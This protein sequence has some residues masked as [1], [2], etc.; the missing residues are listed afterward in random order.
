MSNRSSDG[1]FIARALPR[2]QF[3]RS[4]VRP[5]HAYLHITAVGSLNESLFLPCIWEAKSAPPAGVRRYDRLW[6]Q[7]QSLRENVEGLMD[8]VASLLDADSQ[9][10]YNVHDGALVQFDPL[11][12]LFM[13][14]LPPGMCMRME[15]DKV[16]ATKH[17]YMNRHGYVQMTLF[18]QAGKEVR[19]GAHLFIL[20]ALKG[21]PVSADLSQAMHC[22]PSAIEEAACVHP[23]H[24]RY[25]TPSENAMDYRDRLDR[26]GL[27]HSPRRL[28]NVRS[29]S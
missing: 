20:W 17:T 29:R 2:A 13:E 7:D 25:A 12:S 24:L 10:Y 15:R 23:E 28:R 19:I 21:M 11:R 5:R 9:E 22:C 27:S 16:E 18:Y 14:P 8:I 1:T 26:A 6:I 4:P 3:P